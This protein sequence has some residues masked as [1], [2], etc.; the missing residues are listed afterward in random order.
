MTAQS[1]YK[2]TLL[3]I[4]VLLIRDFSSLQD[5]VGGGSF[6]EDQTLDDC[7]IH[8]RI[9]SC[10]QAKMVQLRLEGSG[11][12]PLLQLDLDTSEEGERLD[13]CLPVPCKD[14]QLMESLKLK[15][16]SIAGSDLDIVVSPEDLDSSF[17]RVQQDNSRCFGDRRAPADVRITCKE[18]S[19]GLYA[20]IYIC[21]YIYT[22]IHNMHVCICAF[23]VCIYIL[24]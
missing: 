22:Y 8:A 6:D 18:E 14:G 9:Y 5:T 21:M 3:S 12:E 11:P 4:N 16:T 10:Q 7:F 24:I 17:E 19:S 23:D 1:C 13:V 15:A 20:Y 2:S